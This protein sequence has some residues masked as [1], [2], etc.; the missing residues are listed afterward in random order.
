MASSSGNYSIRSDMLQNSTSDDYRERRMKANREAARRS[1]MRKQE[2][3]HHLIADISR[4]QKENGQIRAMISLVTQ[5]YSNL[6]NEN[7]VLRSQ[8]AQ[9]QHR[10]HSLNGLIASTNAVYFDQPATLQFLANCASNELIVDDYLGN[11]N[12]FNYPYLSQPTI[13]VPPFNN[14]LFM[15]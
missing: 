3:F 1:R 11:S 7:A 5:A 12:T 9:L 10:L 13:T 8:L 4:Y 15:L 6:M 2:Y 14:C